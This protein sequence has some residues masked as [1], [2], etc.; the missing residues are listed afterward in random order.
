M[1]HGLLGSL[2]P[3]LIEAFPQYTS[4]RIGSHYRKLQEFAPD[5]G[6]EMAVA[7]ASKTADMAWEKA[8]VA[9]EDARLL[10]SD[11]WEGETRA[12]CPNCHT[13]VPP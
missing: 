8:E 2:A 11:V 7:Q 3:S 9:E 13:V 5:V 1:L 4:P 12:A 10:E 6:V